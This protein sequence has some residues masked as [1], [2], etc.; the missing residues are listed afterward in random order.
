[1][2]GSVKYPGSAR[3]NITV[4]T[5]KSALSELL[6]H[7]QQKLHQQSWVTVTLNLLSEFANDKIIVFFLRREKLLCFSNVLFKQSPYCKYFT[8]V[9]QS[10]VSQVSRLIGPTKDKQV[11]G[12]D[13]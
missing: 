6:A 2:K 1:M 3:Q 10:Q 11:Q 9:S 5:E 8:Q 7:I 4:I 13:R 12:M